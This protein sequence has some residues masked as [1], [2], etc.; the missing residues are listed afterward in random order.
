[1]RSKSSSRANGKPTGVDEDGLTIE[2][3]I[4]HAMLI[5]KTWLGS[6][7]ED[8]GLPNC[9]MAQ[10]PLLKGEKVIAKHY[11]HVVGAQE[12]QTQGQGGE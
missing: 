5:R 6:R 10:K 12:H 4:C 8:T 2:L 3:S 9:Y 7:V 11:S 1:M